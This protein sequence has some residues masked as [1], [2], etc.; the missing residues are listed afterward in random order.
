MS[1]LSILTILLK[2]AAYFARRAERSDIEKAVL[3]EIEN[4]H[5]KRVDRAVDARDDVL[6]GRVPIDPDDPNRRD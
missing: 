6:A 2:L 3:N 1:T 5:S 4:I